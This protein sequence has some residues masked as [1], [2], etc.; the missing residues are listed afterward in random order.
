MLHALALAALLLAQDPKAQSK[1]VEDRLKELDEKISALEKKH[2]DLGDENAVLEKKIADGKAAREKFLR[3]SAS[4]W[5]K[6][7]GPSIELNEKQS[8]EFEEL[9]YGWSKEDLE[10][11]YDAARW[12]TRE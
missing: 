6:R 1:T 11:P 3:Q 9:W 10:K 7:Y 5:V 12:K 8:A 2:K 4:A